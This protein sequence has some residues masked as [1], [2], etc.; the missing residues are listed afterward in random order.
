MVSE[1]LSESLPGRGRT[2]SNGGSTNDSPDSISRAG[3]RGA[4]PVPISST[5]LFHMMD[6]PHKIPSY[7]NKY[8]YL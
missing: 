5:M 1:P 6:T 7:L 2:G 3:G 4:I 8:M